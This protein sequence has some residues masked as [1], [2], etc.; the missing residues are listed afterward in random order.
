MKTPL[1]TSFNNVQGLDSGPLCRHIQPYIAHVHEQ[2]Y[3]LKTIRY[4]LRLM[5]NFNRWLVRTG[6]GLRDLDE[7]TIEAFLPRFLGQRTWRAGERPALLRMLC[8]L[9][10]T[11]ATPQAKAVQLTPAQALAT[12]YRQYL[13]KE[14]GCS[15]WTVENYS[16]H[17]DRFLA[18]RFGAGPVRFERLRAQEVIA[19]VQG[20]AG[21]HGHGYTLQVVTGLRSFLRFLRYRGDIITDLAAAVPSV[22]N[23]QKNDLPKHLPADAVQRVLDG[24]DL[25]TAVGRRDYAILILLARLGLRAGEV[26]TLQLEDIDWDNGQLTIRSKKGRGWARLPLP[27]DVGRAISGY[28]RLDRPRCSCRNVFVCMVAPYRHFSTSCVISDLT[29]TA[30]QRAGVESARTGAHLFRHSLA[31]AMLRQGAS[32][33]EIGQVLRHKDPDTTAI[34]AKVDLDALGRL[35][36]AWP[37]GGL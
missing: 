5:A 29:R 4:H 18:R 2:G 28:L 22:A 35:A 14:R 36:V 27:S 31:T 10:K 17:I 16:R 7:R 32:L 6:R 20:E 15:D 8:I 11:R 30:L 37:G 21:R 23:W 1:I 13:T 25:T 9:R 33:D 12:Q 26:V 24:C 19:F 3:K 34:Y